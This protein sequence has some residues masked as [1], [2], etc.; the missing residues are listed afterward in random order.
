M[1]L[2]HAQGSLSLDRDPVVLTPGEAGWRY[3]GLTV[4]ALEP[5][6]ERALRYA[7]DEIVLVPL[8]G[9]FRL[10]SDAL[11]VV[12]EGR[13]DIFRELTD[14]AYLPPGTSFN[15]ASV[16]GGQV[17]VCTARADSGGSPT[18]MPVEHTSVEVRGAGQVTRQV[19]GVWPADIEGPER[20]IVVEVVT[21]DGNW[22]SYPPHKHD[23]WGDNE[24]P[25][26]EIYY[27]RIAGEN[28][29]GIHRTYAADGDIDE[30][31]TVRDGD[32]F[33][34]PRGYHGPCAAAPGYFMY[35]L[36]VMAGPQR[37]WLISNDPA[38]AWVASTWDAVPPDPRL[39][40]S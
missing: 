23:E 19:N 22:S 10:E 4:L 32:V 3:S 16:G 28:G 11:T 27:F 6:E 20:L 37:D 1:T 17:A 31:V 40:T 9:S 18:Y 36:N 39:P 13:T 15:L 25:L 2:Y 7:G 26:E 14:R 30:T 33:L 8:Y 5:G 24:V 12:L 34:I 29:F 21:P 35:Y 38:H